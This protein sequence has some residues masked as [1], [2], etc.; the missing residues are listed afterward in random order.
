MK[1]T[2]ILINVDQGKQVDTEALYYALKEN[3]IAGAGLDQV[4]GLTKNHP[5]LKL[6][7]AVFPPM[8]ALL[9]MSLSEKTYQN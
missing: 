4:A 9:P 2:A 3:K 5:I 7:N 8:R 6:D 1:P